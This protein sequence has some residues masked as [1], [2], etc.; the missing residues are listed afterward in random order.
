MKRVLIGLVVVVGL[1]ATLVG[2]NG[3]GDQP[4]H[5][6]RT[7]ARVVLDGPRIEGIIS[8]AQYAGW[9]GGKVEV[10]NRDTT[11]TGCDE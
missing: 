4:I 2:M 6:P 9:C 3:K 8:A 7:P 10:T 11:V 5:G 1:M